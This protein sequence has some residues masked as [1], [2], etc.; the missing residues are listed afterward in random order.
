MPAATTTDPVTAI[1]ARTVAVVFGWLIDVSFS[2][3]GSPRTTV[4][5]TVD[6]DGCRFPRRSRD[7]DTDSGELPHPHP[8]RTDL[9]IPM[10]HPHRLLPD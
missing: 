8:A 5:R 2:Y 6:H 3:T 4:R 7:F 9:S 1:L 10:I